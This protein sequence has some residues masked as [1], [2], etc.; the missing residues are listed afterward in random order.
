[1]VHPLT[2]YVDSCRV[3]SALAFAVSTRIAIRVANFPANEVAE[4]G[5]RNEEHKHDHGTVYLR[6]R[7]FD[8]PGSRRFYGGESGE[9]RRVQLLPVF[10]QSPWAI[11]FRIRITNNMPVSQS[12]AVPG[13]GV[14]NDREPLAA[15]SR[16]LHPLG[17]QVKLVENVVTPRVTSVTYVSGPDRGNDGG[18][19]GNRTHE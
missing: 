16:G 13:S 1:M 15:V 19:G 11:R 17:G 5:E 6:A 9:R 18:A 14:T 10:S 7:D 3:R 4:R 2:I 8:T 12:T